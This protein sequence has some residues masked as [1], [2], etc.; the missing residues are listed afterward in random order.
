MVISDGIT[1][2]VQ[3]TQQAS[4]T[5]EAKPASNHE[6]MMQTKNVAVMEAQLKVSSETD[7]QS[8]LLL[9]KTKN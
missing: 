7:S 4:E 2:P 3:P 8:M 9:Y 1:A 6:Q 5:Q